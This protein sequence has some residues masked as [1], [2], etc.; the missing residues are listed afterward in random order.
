LGT[1]GLKMKITKQALRNLRTR[2]EKGLC[3]PVD[4]LTNKAFYGVKL[5]GGNIFS[6]EKDNRGRRNLLVIFPADL[7]TLIDEDSIDGTRQISGI[8]DSSNARGISLNNISS[9]NLGDVASIIINWE[10]RCLNNGEEFADKNIS[11]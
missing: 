2:I 1:G 6:F 3:V 10:K 4:V 5:E 9:M 7:T 8:V 11:K